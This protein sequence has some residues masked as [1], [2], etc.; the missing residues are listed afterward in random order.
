MPSIFATY[1][2]KAWPFR[3]A[4]TLSVTDIHGGVPADPK[5]VESWL[6]L[7]VREKDAITQAHI[8]DLITDRGI[9]ENEA[10]AALAAEKVNGFTR[11]ERGL[12]I[13]GNHLKAC[14]KEGVNVAANAGKIT[15]KGWG[16]PDNANYK[17]GI[18]AWFP[19]H[20]FIVENRLYLGTAEAD[21]I[22]QRFT[23]SQHGSSITREEVVRTADISFTVESDHPFTEEQWAMIWL[24]CGRQGLGTSRSQGF[25]QFEVTSW[26][27]A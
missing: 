19:E 9:D 23:H 27:Q 25:G 5:T 10:V 16:T 26:D 8:A 7:K 6:L 13:P 12:Y 18:K 1:E 11:D 3:H 2:S 21:Y 20:V 4:G 14:L 15:T 17:K 24:T 22:D